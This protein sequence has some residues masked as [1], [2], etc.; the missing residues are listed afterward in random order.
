MTAALQDLKL[1]LRGLLRSPGV[2]VSA[3]VCLALG[4]GV[5]AAM[6][7]VLDLILLRAPEH[8]WD[9]DSLKRLY[10]RKPDADLPQSIVSYPIFADLAGNVDAF[11][12]LAAFSR[13]ESSLGLGPEARRVRVCLVTP[14]FFP[15]LGV[16]PVRGRLFSEAEG[17]PERLHPV[18]LVSWELWQRG[19]GG[20]PDVLG[21]PLTIDRQL[22]TVVGV[23]P[24]RF[25]GVDLDPVDVWLP[26]GAAG[27]LGPGQGWSQNR[28]SFFLSV[29]ARL[30]PGV[31]TAQAAQQATA[32]HRGIYAELGD[33]PAE[34]AVLLEPVQWGRVPEG[35]RTV[36][37]AAW[38]AAGSLAVLGIACANVAS[39]LLVRSLERRRE[40]AVRLALGAS[41][42]GLARLLLAEGLLLAAL[43][44]LAAYAALGFSGALLRAFLLPEGT[45]YGNASDLRLLLI[46][47]S[48]SLGAGL[49]SGLGAAL[50]GG[51]QELA[52]AVRAGVRD[53]GLGRSRLRAALL[54][55]QVAFTFLLLVGAGLFLRSLRNV[56]NLPLGLEPELV[57]AMTTDLAG[58]GYT[59]SQ[60]DAYSRLALDR[61][62]SLPGVERASL[63]AGIPFRSSFGTWLA[64]PGRGDLSGSAP[65]GIYF[66][67]V[68]EDFFSTLG[69]PLLAGRAFTGQDDAGAQ[70]MAVVNA[71]LAKLLWP[72]QDPLGRCFQSLDETIPC[73]T[74]V[75]VVADARR[76]GLREPPTAQF[77]VPLA[78]APEWLT[79]RA[80]FV[81]AAAAPD[82]LAG[83][84]RRELQSLAPNLPFIEV[85]RLSD[86]LAP[87]VRPWRMGAT[88]FS[89]FGL[90]ALVLAVLGVFAAVAQAVASRADELGIR[91][92]VG[93]HFRDLLWLVMR[94]GLGPA[95]AGVALGLVLAAGIGRFVEPLL[96]EV[97]AWDFAATS[98]AVLALLAAALLASLVPALRV[99]RLDPAAVMR[100]E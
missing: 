63:A 38:L 90:L 33:R 84:V 16:Q 36:R 4:I 41:R 6:L 18:A 97:A 35:A 9:A 61:V 67:A 86:L 43:G 7:G 47:A 19:L 78:Q 45:P 68:T 14:G 80:L 70:R 5:N 60:V 53:R 22:Y 57:L 28:N 96:F 1:A 74:V 93:A 39:L 94:F 91:M 8:V 98:A 83:A 20:A 30:R 46:L 32:I 62:R 82:R 34:R 79:S 49:L 2:L 77:Y 87:Q 89:L 58:A 40:L 50:W 3:V 21:Q 81:R 42:A 59:P 52:G 26:I 99:R 88:I 55:S 72:G 12:G 85:R 44:G 10:F 100:T 25:T 15:L 75:G 56:E 17:D 31:S 11:S 64:V 13:R 66:N 54:V 92:A 65:G 73:I 51:R 76:A 71:T 37:L 48:V 27:P 29:V 95:A 23:L 24:R 69:T